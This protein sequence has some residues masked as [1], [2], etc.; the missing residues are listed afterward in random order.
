LT[1]AEA[2]WDWREPKQ[3]RQIGCAHWFLLRSLITVIV[4]GHAIHRILKST[5]FTARIPALTSDRCTSHE[6]FPP[7]KRVDAPCC[8][9]V[10]WSTED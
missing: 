8:A 2:G 5:V 1:A 3:V 10:G 6:V 9:V 7:G 4:T